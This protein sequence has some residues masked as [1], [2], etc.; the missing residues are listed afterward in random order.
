MTKP[1][2]RTA[3]NVASS[4]SGG[5]LARFFWGDRLVWDDADMTTV[6]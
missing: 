2:R 5:G 4:D 6:R 1:Q 3:K